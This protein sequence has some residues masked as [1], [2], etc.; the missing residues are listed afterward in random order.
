MHSGQR[1]WPWTRLGIDG[2]VK[3]VRI[4][5]CCGFW[6]LGP[7]AVAMACHGTLHDSIGAAVP[8]TQ[9][10][11]KSAAVPVTSA[12]TCDLQLHFGN[13]TALVPVLGVQLQMYC[14]TGAD[15]VPVLGMQL[16]MN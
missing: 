7:L 12:S 10:L 15:L 14:V 11:F 4:T 3:E 1:S 9:Y 13:C 6:Q 5:R 16:Q 2:L 8:V